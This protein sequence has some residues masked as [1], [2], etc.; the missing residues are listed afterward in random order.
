MR[1]LLVLCVSYLLGAIPT[2]YLLTRV[3]V[4]VDVRE[5]GSGSTGATNVIRTAGRWAGAATLLL[6]AAK[7]T[8]AVLIA[9]WSGVQP[10]GPAEALALLAVVAG[11]VFPVTLGFRG[12]KGVAC[13]IG[14]ALVFSPLAAG[15]GLAGL[16]GVVAATRWVSLGSLVFAT[17]LPVAHLAVR[18]PSVELL[19][20]LAACLLVVVRHTGNIRRLMAGREPRL[21]EG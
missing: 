15:V 18:G 11:H 16:A 21:G 2:G 4:G 19:P 6:D 8:A 12:G 5:R 9:R 3:A 17:L 1:L 20:L 13:T 14:G 10:A 7:G